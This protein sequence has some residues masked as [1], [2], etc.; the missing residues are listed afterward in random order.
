VVQAFE[1]LALLNLGPAARAWNHRMLAEQLA[2]EGRRGLATNAKG[3]LG[4]RRALELG[5]LPVPGERRLLAQELASIYEQAR[6]SPPADSL[7]EDAVVRARR[8]LCRFA[9]VL[10]A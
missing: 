2:L 1:Y 5:V 3:W 10:P 7:P 9:G 4:R 8:D 6:Y